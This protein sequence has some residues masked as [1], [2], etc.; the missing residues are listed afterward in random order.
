MVE[1]MTENLKDIDIKSDVLGDY[2]ILRKLGFTSWGVNLLAEHRFI[3]RRFVL[4]VLLS[5]FASSSDFIKSFEETV[6][7]LAVLDHPGIAKV[8]NVSCYEGHFFLVTED[9]GQGDPAS[10]LSLSRYLS[11]RREG[12]K[13]SETIA[14]LKKVA[15]ALDYAHGKGVI[16][17]CL[18][19]DNIF[20]CPGIEEPEVIVSDFGLSFLTL[21]RSLKLIFH[22]EDKILFRLSRKLAFLSPELKR[23]D[24]EDIRSDS[25]SFGVLVYYLLF[26]EIPEGFL[27]IPES[28]SKGN[29]NWLKVLTSC[30]NAC[31]SERPD[32]LSELF[33]DK[34][35][36]SESPE[37]RSEPVEILKRDILIESALRTSEKN[38]EEVFYPKKLQTPIDTGSHT[39]R[40]SMKSE[41]EFVLVAAKSIDAVMETEVESSLIRKGEVT[42]HDEDKGKANPD[43]IEEGYSSALQA[44]LYKDPIVCRYAS[45]DIIECKSEPLLTETAYI[46]GGEFLRGS[47]EGKRDEQPISKV[48][49]DSFLMDIHPVTNEQFI[50]F[51]EFS[52]GEKD[53]NYNDLIRLKESRIQRRSGKLFIETGYDKHPVV[54]VTWYGASGYAE[55][56]GK[57]LPTEAEWEIASYGGKKTLFPTGDTIDKHSANFFSSDTTPV[58][59]YPPNSTGLYDMAGNVY[60]WCR[61]WYGYD[62]YELSVTEPYSPMGPPQGVYRVLRGGCWKSLKEDL[63]CSHR[64]RNNPGTVNSTY[65]FRCVTDVK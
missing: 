10:G 3:K 50:R 26:G 27:N 7:K 28:F 42:E 53:R 29:F 5:E 48:I 8:Q 36:R 30:L 43:I 4:Q 38:R 24:A 62:Y 64:H 58:M 49:L 18:N 65:G 21:E 12:L 37:L 31:G 13:E 17:A 52:G 40:F 19:P 2:K 55:W 32:N 46:E 45:H 41:P 15:A 63:R 47:R 51:L 57:R 9:F 22:E 25:Y 54:G 34:K 1:K 35:I 20:V 60:E 6:I 14:I 44:M 61:D 33:S 39:H 16:H 11:G 23:G 59:S 56:V